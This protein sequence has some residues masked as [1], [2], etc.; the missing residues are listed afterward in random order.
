MATSEQ[1]SNTSEI[2]EP[3]E[4]QPGET[5]TGPAQ[6]AAETGNKPE[7]ETPAAPATEPAPAPEQNPAQE[8]PVTPEPAPAPEPTPAKETPATPQT[9]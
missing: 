7:T 1:E 6:T 4:N 2:K 5:S 9:S 3:Q 8:T